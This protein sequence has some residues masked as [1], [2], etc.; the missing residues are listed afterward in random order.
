MLGFSR[1]DIQIGCLLGASLWL[2]ALVGSADAGREDYVGSEACGK[3][4]AEA[5]TVWKDSAHARA[6][7]SL[8]ARPAARCQGCH[9]TGEAPAGRVF[10]AGVG[11]EACH[12]PGAGY[13]EDDIMRNARL[14]GLLGLRDLSTP[15]ARAALCAGCHRASTRLRAFDAERAFERIAHPDNESA[16]KESTEKAPRGRPPEE[17]SGKRDATRSQP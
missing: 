17:D 16:E 10:F 8:G 9:T 3:C 1:C 12:G 5:Y 11:C 4:H 2:V 14:A 15:A 6:D 13:A 7:R